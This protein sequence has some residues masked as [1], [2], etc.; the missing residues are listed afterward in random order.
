MKTCFVTSSF[1]RAASPTFLIARK[2]VRIKTCKT[3]D[4][5]LV[6]T[7]FNSD[8]NIERTKQFNWE[9]TV[10]QTVQVYRSLL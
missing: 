4:Y 3:K 6:I 7:H 1:A 5:Y 8:L 10:M 2:M 9:K